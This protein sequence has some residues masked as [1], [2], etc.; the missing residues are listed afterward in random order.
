MS[1]HDVLISLE[2]RLIELEK[3]QKLRWVHCLVY[4]AT[5]S[6]LCIGIGLWLASPFW[7]RGLDWFTVTGAV[8]LLLAST[9]T[10]AGWVDLRLRST[11]G[12]SSPARAGVYLSLFVFVP[13]CPVIWLL[14]INFKW[15]MTLYLYL[16]EQPSLFKTLDF[17]SCAILCLKHRSESYAMILFNITWPWP[18]QRHKP[19]RAPFPKFLQRICEVPYCTTRRLGS[20]L[21]KDSQHTA[22]SA[23]QRAILHHDDMFCQKAYGYFEASTL[24]C[25]FSQAQARSR[26]TRSNRD[27]LRS[28]ADYRNDGRAEYPGYF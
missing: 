21:P 28:F 20:C 1:T 17:K 4:L 3:N 26:D 6:H 7:K 9:V 10:P 8:V 23:T 14:L 13:F 12:D 25:P 5:N 11:F 27:S 24:F 16:Y 15:T 2:A 18:T 22:W 19:F